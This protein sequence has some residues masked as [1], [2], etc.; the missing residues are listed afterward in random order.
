MQPLDFFPV[1][2]FWLLTLG[3]LAGGLQLAYRGLD[4]YRWKLP[5]SVRRACHNPCEGD[6]IPCKCGGVAVATVYDD[7]TA[8]EGLS[9]YATCPSCGEPLEVW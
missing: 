7:P 4:R 2:A 1:A 8:F 5:E 6:L 3:V 9:V